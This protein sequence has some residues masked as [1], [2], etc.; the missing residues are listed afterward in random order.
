MPVAAVEGCPVSTTSLMLWRRWRSPSPSALVTSMMMTRNF[1]LA[2]LLGL[3]VAAPAFAEND[4]QKE[5]NAIENK[6]NALEKKA[7]REKKS[8]DQLEI[9][10]Q[11]LHGRHED[12]QHAAASLDT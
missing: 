1:V 11:R 5:G 3:A 10:L 2:S 9:I 7:E 4:V 8:A 12:V 6:G